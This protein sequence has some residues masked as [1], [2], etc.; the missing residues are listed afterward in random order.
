[1]K[2]DDTGVKNL[3]CAIVRQAVQDWRNAM[4]RLKKNP[5]NQDAHGIVV[6][7]ERFFLSGYF[8][9]LTGMDGE[10]FLYRL[11]ERYGFDVDDRKGSDAR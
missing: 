2:L 7:C 6:D 3:T 5:R 8:N 4:R 11:M 1:M 9:T 10:Q